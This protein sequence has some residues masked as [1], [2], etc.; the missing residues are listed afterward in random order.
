MNAL[1]Q[2]QSWENSDMITYVL[3]DYIRIQNRATSAESKELR[4]L[5]ESRMPKDLTVLL[6]QVEVYYNDAIK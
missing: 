5:W 3:I 1:I 2:Y 4:K 6:D